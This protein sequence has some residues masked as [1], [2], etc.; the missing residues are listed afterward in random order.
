M[1][2]D[3]FL[4]PIWERGELALLHRLQSFLP[5]EGWGPYGRD[6]GEYGE[7]VIVTKGNE[8][9]GRIVEVWSAK[10]GRIIKVDESQLS[11]MGE[12]GVRVVADLTIKEY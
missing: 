3:K 7:R 8:E 4:T 1:L 2:K 5:F 11:P 12:E 9:G 10:S 6:K